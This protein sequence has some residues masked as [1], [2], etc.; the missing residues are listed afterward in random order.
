MGFITGRLAKID[1]LQN[2]PFWIVATIEKGVFCKWSIH[3]DCLSHC[4]MRPVLSTH[5]RLYSFNNKIRLKHGQRI[6]CE[7]RRHFRHLKI[8]L[9]NKG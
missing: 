5:L 8:S 9:G 6:S 4:Y 2:T 3:L 7:G 1:H